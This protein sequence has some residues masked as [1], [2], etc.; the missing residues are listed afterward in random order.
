MIS[1]DGYEREIHEL[2]DKIVAMRREYAKA[3]AARERRIA[4]L[5]SG[6]HVD[7]K[8]RLALVEKVVQKYHGKRSGV[9]RNDVDSATA[10]LIHKIEMALRGEEYT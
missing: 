10:Y 2:E 9:I 5:E 8:H 6:D 3:T 1:P 7:A 4:D